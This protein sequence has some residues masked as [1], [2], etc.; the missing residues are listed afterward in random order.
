MARI[1]PVARADAAPEVRAVYDRIFSSGRDPVSE[2]GTATGSP[3]DFWTVLANVP[4]VITHIIRFAD[5]FFGPESQLSGQLREVVICR[6]AFNIGS[7]FEYSQHRKQL[8]NFDYPESKAA[9]I[10]VWAS[11]DLF[12]AEER[13]LLAYV[14]ELTL[15]AGRTQD[16]TFERLQSHFSDVQ[17]IEA[18]YVA[19]HYVAYGLLIKSLRLEYDD[20]SERV[21][22]VLST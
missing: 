21:E 4:G 10:P 3:G 18:A 7:K 8:R 2:P 12:S 20:I 13:A 1:K 16:A 14:D 9:D 6:T 19:A 15:C 22:E 5:V 11:S 17:I